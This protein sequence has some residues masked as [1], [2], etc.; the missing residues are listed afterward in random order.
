MVK[1]KQKHE[2]SKT[3]SSSSQA[4]NSSTS[5]QQTTQQSN[6]TPT[7]QQTEQP[8]Q[9]QDALATTDNLHDFVN[10]Y[11]ESPAA[12]KME[13]QGMSA[14]DALLS[15]PDNMKSSGEIQATNMYR[16]GQDPYADN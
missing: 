1:H 7:N 9:Q 3:K 13:H 10:K 12:Y 6:Q 16:Q 5:Q 15:T 8:Q 2:D 11:G 14:R 4:T